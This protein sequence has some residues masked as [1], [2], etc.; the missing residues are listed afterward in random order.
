MALNALIALLAFLAGAG[1]AW[2]IVAARAASTR[3]DFDARLRTAE[4]ALAVERQRLASREAAFSEAEGRFREAFASLA[5][6]ALRA[7]ADH[8]AARSAEALEAARRQAV[9]DLELRQQA[10]GGL[11]APINE[12]LHKVTQRVEELDRL[13]QEAYGALRQNLDDVRLG[14]QTVADQ[15]RQLVQALRAPQVRGRWGE[16]QLHRVVELAG[17]AEHVDFTQQ[18]SVAAEGGALRPDLVVRLPGG[19]SIIVDAKTPL[20]AYLR[21]V[22]ATDEDARAA[23]LR[24]HGQQLR[25]HIGQLSAKAYWDQFP[26]A[27]DFVVMFV[28]GEAFLS[29]ACLEDPALLEAAL[30]KRVILASPTLLVALLRTIA[31]GWRQEKLAE[32]ALRIS[33]DARELH[34]RIAV[35]A[36]HFVNMGS[37]LGKAVESYN[38]GI[39]SLESR[40]LVTAR[41]LTEFG[42]TVTREIAEAAPVDVAVRPVSAPELL[43]APGAPSGP[44]GPTLPA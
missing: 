36:E 23:A 16:M 43:A 17:L 7:N 27:P 37:R 19:R 10:I 6:D 34:D 32:H 28:P 30:D 21:A 35:M 12:H 13:R 14:Q 1:L 4:T 40:V 39:G 8:F 11:V 26:D 25:T 33:E 29:A 3:R 42:L 38:A 5:A 20:D 31:A 15:A 2:A 41:R 22:E 24:Q 18:V 44:A 9:Q